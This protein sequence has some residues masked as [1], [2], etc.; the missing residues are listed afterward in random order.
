MKTVGLTA[1]F[2]FCLWA[3]GSLAG[4]PDGATI[5]DLLGS[6]RD[7]QPDVRAFEYNDK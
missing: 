7:Q 2:G 1:R 3:F 5:H 4:N 6:P